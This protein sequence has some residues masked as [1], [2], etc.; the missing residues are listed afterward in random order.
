MTKWSI[1]LGI[2]GILGTCLV[3]AYL[4]RQESR[5][6][7]GRSWLLGLAAIA[8]AWLI[9][10]LALLEYNGSLL[11]DSPLPPSVL[12]SSAAALLGVIVTDW[13]VRRLDG[14]G[15]ARHPGTY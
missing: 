14:K 8:P 9:S 6:S 12:A 10:L 15:P 1:V 2:F 13:A 4:S 3:A 11:P 5:L 7:P